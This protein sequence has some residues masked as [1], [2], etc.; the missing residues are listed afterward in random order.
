MNY[1]LWKTDNEDRQISGVFIGIIIAAIV[2]FISIL[3]ATWFNNKPMPS[4]YA[5]ER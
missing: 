5:G 1:K 2:I 3:L 4:I